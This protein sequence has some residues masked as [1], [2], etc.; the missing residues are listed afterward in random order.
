VTRPQKAP[1]FAI[2]R[3]RNIVP[4]VRSEA[5][6]LLVEEIW[7]NV[8]EGAQRTGYNIDHVRRLARENLR[9][10]EDERLMRVR[11]ETRAYEIWLPDLINY[12]E[13]RIPHS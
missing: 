13:R 6:F 8:E 5:G 9:L 12:V 2:I 11:K 10:P 7:V 4:P 1:Q 3:E